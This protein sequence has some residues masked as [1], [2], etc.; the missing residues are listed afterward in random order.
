M[1]SF[2]AKRAACALACKPPSSR[3]ILLLSDVAMHVLQVLMQ[4][5]ACIT[6]HLSAHH[7]QHRRC[8]KCANTQ[9]LDC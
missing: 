9:I 6:S 4:M 7:D 5:V 3:Q 2:C 1:E 8:C